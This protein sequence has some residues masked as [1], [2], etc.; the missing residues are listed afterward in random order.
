MFSGIV[1]TTGELLSQKQEKN[2]VRWKIKKP[3]T[4]NDLSSGESIAVDGVC[5][6]IEQFNDSSM[7]FAIA[8]ETLQVLK[9]KQRNWD[10]KRFNL[11]RSLQFGERVHGHLVTGHVDS[12]ATVI[13][14]KDL[15]DCLI[16]DFK[17]EDHVLA[18]I[19]H[20]GSLAINGVSLTLNE[21]QN[22]R[23]SV[24]LIPETLKRTNLGDLQIGD[25]VC[26]EPDYMARAIVRGLE[27][28][29]FQAKQNIN[30]VASHKKGSNEQ[31]N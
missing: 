14:R 10:N 8:A 23:I 21:V 5:L 17:V 15:Q 11:E 19:W 9:W 4:F 6:T 13:D 12:L 3:D 26:I 18:Y 20:K 27:I 25:F 2:I 7:T 31:C 16:L 30:P 22:N 24:C 28:N 1:E 29:A